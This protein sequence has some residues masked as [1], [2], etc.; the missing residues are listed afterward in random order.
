MYLLLRK[1][2]SIWNEVECNSGSYQKFEYLS[3]AINFTILRII[4]LWR[5]LLLFILFC[6]GLGIDPCSISNSLIFNRL[7]FDCRIRYR[8]VGDSRIFYY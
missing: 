7:T 3:Y 6:F 1:G 2:F 5:E 4:I 8:R